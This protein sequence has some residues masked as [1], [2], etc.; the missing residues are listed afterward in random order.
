MLLSILYTLFLAGL[1][2]ADLKLEDMK[3]S[4]TVS[5]GIDLKWK[6]DGQDPPL[7]DFPKTTILLCTGS[8]SD[9]D[10]FKDTPLYDGNLQ[11]LKGEK[12]LPLT[13]VSALGGNGPYFI[14]MVAIYKG[15]GQ[16]ILYSDRF[17]LTGMTGD[18]KASDGGDTSPPD[19]SSTAGQMSD[20]EQSSE[21]KKS[22]TKQ[23][24]KTRVAP[25]QLQPATKVTRSLKATQRL[26][27]SSV[28]S[29]F[30]TIT[31]PPNVMSTITPGWSYTFEAATNWAK[32]QPTPTKAY[33]ASAAQKSKIAKLKPSKGAKT[34][35]WVD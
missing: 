18:K 33:A 3:K 14:Q 30:T 5:S 8:N 12:K 13:Q 35:R 2:L 31:G 6:D 22:Y 17:K 11:S 9:I 21:G 32:T 1:A 20:A 15:Q 26:P 28:S 16:T 7:K 19:G 4:Y 24:K 34:K 23:T 29:Y 27:K 10:C 25:M